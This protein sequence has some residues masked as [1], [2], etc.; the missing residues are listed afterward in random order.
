V[1]ISSDG[2]VCA[3]WGGRS[4][5]QQLSLTAAHEL[6]EPVADRT[7]ARRRQ[8]PVPPRH[9]QGDRV[10]DGVRPMRASPRF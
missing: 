10:L 7:L 1:V 3:A 4:I 6:G 8:L 9:E 5:T 2:V